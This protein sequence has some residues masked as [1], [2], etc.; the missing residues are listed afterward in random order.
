MIRIII[1]LLFCVGCKASLLSELSEEV[2]NQA[3]VVL[4]RYR[5]PAEKREH[6]D[7]KNRGLFRIVV[8]KEM[9]GTAL[10]VLK[11]QDVPSK[12]SPGF[13]L[14]FEK[15][16]LI[17]TI[18]EEEARYVSALSGELMSSIETIE[19]VLDARV[20]I[21]L[22]STHYTSLEE[23]SPQARASVLIKYKGEKLPYE[24]DEIRLLVAGAV[25]EMNPE[26]VVVV[27]V[28]AHITSLPIDQYTEIGPI[29]IARRSLMAFKGIVGTSLLFNILLALAMIGLWKY[30][31]K[32]IYT[33][34]K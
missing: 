27:G 6:S 3:I 9:M 34:H 14:L 5:I 25:Q 30:T 31:K 22:S 7:R 20:H 18:K 15:S 16:G 28:R 29:I 24:P 4:N 26:N 17:P 12:S 32:L 19:N 21:A 11:E 23:K 8:S 1:C 2:A 10:E 33:H 13:D